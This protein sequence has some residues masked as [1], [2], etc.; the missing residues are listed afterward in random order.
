MSYGGGADVSFGTA[1]YLPIPS[2]NFDAISRST[3]TSAIQSD[4]KIVV[5]GTI[6]SAS[7]TGSTV[8]TFSVARYDAN[9]MID[10]GFGSAGF[11]SDEKLSYNVFNPLESRIASAE[12]MAIQPDGKIVV[13]GEVEDVAKVIRLNADGT[14]DP[15]FGSGGI[16]T[17]GTIGGTGDLIDFAESMALLPSGEIAVAG[18]YEPT[19]GIEAPAVE[20]LAANGS[21]VAGFNNGGLALVPIPARRRDVPTPGPARRPPRHQPA[22]RPP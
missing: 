20:L 11:F 19:A 8:F 9:G 15:N 12:A 21:I 3:T 2:N 4:G 16:V 13:V 5:A 7:P 1:G 22:P 17:L 6:L 10:Q 14:L 18:F